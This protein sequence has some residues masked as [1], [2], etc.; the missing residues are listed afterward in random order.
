MRGPI[1]GYFVWD[2]AD[3]ASPLQLAAGGSGIVPFRSVLRSRAGLEGPPAPARLLYSARSLDDVIYRAELDRG[4]PGLTITYALTRRQ[5]PGWAGPAG[6]VGAAL[7]SQVAWP[8]GHDPL[9][10]V[11][12]P[13]SFVETV[14]AGLTGLG[15]RPDRV[16]AER[17]GGPGGR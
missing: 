4:Q 2:A 11:C 15:Y 12:G 8:A 10:F 16:K 9:A 6:R 14:A 17:Y 7:L 3:A 5:P 1:G 13:T